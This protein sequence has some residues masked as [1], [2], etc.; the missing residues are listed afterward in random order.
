MLWIRSFA[1]ANKVINSFISFTHQPFQYWSQGT[2]PPDILELQK[3]WNEELAKLGLQPIR[4]FDKKSASQW[5]KN[6]H[7][8]LHLAFT[9]APHYAVESDVFRIAFAAQ[10]NCIYLD[11]DSFPTK[12]TISELQ[13]KLISGDTTLYFSKDRPYVFNGFFA[14]KKNSPIFRHMTSKMKNFT[15]SRKIINRRAIEDSFVRD[16]S[17]K[18]CKN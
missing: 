13:H 5:I 11:C 10:N 14:T 17:P 18:R 7:P 9:T 16:C 3:L 12:Y 4:L 2:P 8:S 6:N 15:F 1:H